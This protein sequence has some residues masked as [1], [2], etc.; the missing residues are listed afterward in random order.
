MFVYVHVCTYECADSRVWEGQRRGSGGP[1]EPSSPL[2]TGSFAD[3]EPVKSSPLIRL[4]SKPQR[5]GCLCLRSTDLQEHAP[6]RGVFCKMC[7]WGLE[8]RSPCLPTRDFTL[9]TELSPWSQRQM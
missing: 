4:T 3:L 2:E 6:M 5:A 8:L 1:W 7:V 9:P